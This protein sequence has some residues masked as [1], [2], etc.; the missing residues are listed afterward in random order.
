M[1]KVCM[2]TSNHSPLDCRIFYKEGL[3]LQKHGFT[4]TIAAPVSNAGFVKDMS[5]NDVMKTDDKLTLFYN[6]VKFRGFRV[7]RSSIP[8]FNYLMFLIRVTREIVKVG[9]EENAD[10][11]HC[12]EFTSLIAGVRIKKRMRRMGRKVKLI[13]DVHEYWSGV[14]QQKFKKY[15]IIGTFLKFLFAYLEHKMSRVCDLI[16]TSNQIVRGYYLL[17]NRFAK[18][19]VLY[20]CCNLK[21]FKEI[22][23]KRRNEYKVLCHEGTLTFNRG[24][25]NMIYVIKR[26]KDYGEK[27]K[28]LIVGDV[29]GEEKEWLEKKMKDFD[30]GDNIEKTGWVSYEKVG[31]HIAKA[32]IGIILMRPTINN[33]LAGPPN[34]LFNYM[35]YGLP[36]VV[37]DFPEIRRIVTTNNC[38]IIVNT[39]DVENI[40]EGIRYLFSNSA[41]SKKMGKNGKEAVMREYNW[42]EMEKRL[43][44]I[45]NEI[46]TFQKIE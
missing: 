37:P 10:I 42:G 16:I 34:K 44:K 27:V 29:F 45:Y 7:K 1:K 8:K 38:G 35:R 40:C 22:K 25:K 5:G 20:N 11:Y 23:R 9:L 12:H 33:M 46:Q 15:Y 26:L 2:L 41:E 39:I 28:L 13:Y 31:E 3:S 32:D 18:V 43:I 19:E 17:H 4:V 21:L 14:Y 24:L 6:N 36:A 30:L